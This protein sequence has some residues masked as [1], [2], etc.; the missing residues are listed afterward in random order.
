MGVGDTPR[1]DDT[2]QVHRADS[3]QIRW[4]SEGD[5]LTG[6]RLSW[7]T[8]VGSA[9]EMES[10]VTAIVA[11]VRPT[12]FSTKAPDTMAITAPAQSAGTNHHRSATAWSAE[13]LP[14][15]M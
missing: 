3:L 14:S 11:R 1:G 2:Q 4:A 9:S 8:N 15:R 12:R 10:S 6:V 13:A 5:S 7:P